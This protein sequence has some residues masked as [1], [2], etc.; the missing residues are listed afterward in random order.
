MTDDRPGATTA[1]LFFQLSGPVQAWSDDESIAV[2]PP[3]RRAVLAM[4]LLAEGRVV[5]TDE[6]VTGIWGEQP[7]PRTT[8]ALQAH[9]SVLRRVLEPGR[10]PRETSRILLSV[11]RGY[12]LDLGGARVDLL[13]FRRRR[14]AARAARAARDGGRTVALLTDA[15]ADWSGDALVGLPGPAAVTQRAVLQMERLAA[16]EDLLEALLIHEPSA[17]PV[18]LGP[19]LREHPHRERL[20]ALAIRVLHASGRRADALALYRDLRHRLVDDL[21]IEPG[22]QVRALQK[23]ILV[24]DTTRTGELP[25]VSVPRPPGPLPGRSDATA[26]AVSATQPV[27]VQPRP[28]PPAPPDVQPGVP[29]P[30]ASQPDPFRPVRRA[31]GAPQV[32]S[33]QAARAGVPLLTVAPTVTWRSGLV[34]RDAALDALDGLLHRGQPQPVVVH[35]LPGVGTTAVAVGA[36]MRAQTRFP[37]GLH[38]L[39]GATV[40]TPPAPGSLVVIDGVHSEAQLD[41][42]L[43]AP[44]GAGVAMVQRLTAD[45]VA[46][47]VTG[48]DRLRRIIPAHRVEIAPLTDGESYA[49]LVGHLGATRIRGQEAAVALLARSTLGLPAAVTACAEQLVARPTWTVADYVDDLCAQEEADPR[50]IVDVGLGPFVRHAYDA[51]EPAA[52]GLLVECVAQVRP[53]GRSGLVEFERADVPVGGAAPDRAEATRLLAVLADHHLLAEFAPGRFRVPPA[54]RRYVRPLGRLAAAV[55][56]A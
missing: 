43:G 28:Y 22:P 47:L 10:R 40:P 49:L 18:E 29:Q 4:L 6:L 35:G 19:T 15:L 20:H 14:E 39:D 54:V 23:A 34:G 52:F 30:G 45:G 8:A 46:V 1:P 5:S 48:T 11:G 2:G 24:E 53:S 16:F 3:Q 55:P 27:R 7:P 9:V 33:A 50:W 36:V 44:Q 21:G 38:I 26:D 17:I 25:A 41:H 13:V 32:G 12:C 31:A 56:G 37:A 42:R 51:L